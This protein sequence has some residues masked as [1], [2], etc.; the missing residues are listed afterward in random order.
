MVMSELFCQQ[1][2]PQMPL[3]PQSS[4]GRYPLARRD[5]GFIGVVALIGKRTANPFSWFL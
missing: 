3:T 2:N 4:I 5:A 1:T